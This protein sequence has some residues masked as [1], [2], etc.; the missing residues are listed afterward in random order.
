MPIQKLACSLLV[1]AAL[2]ATGTAIAAE[3]GERGEDESWQ[4]EQRQHIGIRQSTRLTVSRSGHEGIDQG[5]FD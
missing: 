5:D 2:S 3:G 1:A 4:I